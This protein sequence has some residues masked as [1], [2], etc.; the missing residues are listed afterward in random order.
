MTL[1][2]MIRDLN[3]PRCGHEHTLEVRDIEEP[4]TVGHNVVEVP[5]R[6][7]VC[8]YCG[9]RVFDPVA[10]SKIDTVIVQMRAG[11]LAQFIHVGEV[12]RVS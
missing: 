7:G 3:C 9:E 12:Y 6:A 5:L 10:M 2:E 8:S 11:N 1:A 4:L